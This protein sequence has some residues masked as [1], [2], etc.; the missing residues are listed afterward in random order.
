MP[1]RL[2]MIQSVSGLILALFM[3]VHLLLVASI[4]ISKDAMYWVAGVME[5]RF[6]SADG[7]GYPWL[8]ALF[9]LLILVVFMVHGLLAMRKFPANW[10]QWQ[11]LDSHIRRMQHG[12]TTLWRWQAVTGFIMF[13]LGSAHLIIMA[14]DAD[15]IGP[16]LSADRFISEGLWPMYLILLLSVEIHGVTGMYRLAVKWGLF[17]G[18]D[19]RRT[20]TRLKR[21][22]IALT[23]FF[24]ALGLA[25]F[26][27]Y[28]KI[29]LEHAPQAGQ[30][31][32]PGLDQSLAPGVHSPEGKHG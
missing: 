31:Y 22:K 15:K 11:A 20:R 7:H 6:L 30:R 24:L 27:A 32:Q 19:P 23:L 12:D 25:T 4:L 14:M 21:L 2:D 29:G 13:F 9:A 18:D 5:A 10:R 1:A 8:V 28:V 16:H 3:W 26:A 17:D